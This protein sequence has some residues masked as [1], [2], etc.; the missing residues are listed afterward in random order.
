M[1]DCGADGRLE[2]C[3]GAADVGACCDQAGAESTHA[4]AQI[5]IM[6]AITLDLDIGNFL[7]F[8]ICL[9]TKLDA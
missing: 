6:R 3:G 7:S 4:T 8:R 9:E 2:F 1:E 5:R